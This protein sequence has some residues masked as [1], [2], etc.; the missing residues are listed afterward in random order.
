[1]IRPVFLVRAAFA[2]MTF[3]V[4]PVAAPAVA[5]DFR[6]TVAAGKRSAI[7]SFGT[8]NT[9]TCAPSAVPQVRVAQK[10]EHGK[11]EVVEERRVMNAGRCGRVE[12]NLMM[13]YY[14][15]VAGYRGP[16]AGSID[17]FSFAF[18]EGQKMRSTRTSFQITVK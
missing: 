4:M 11:I 6:S 2:A 8:Y 13:I 18:A 1:M 10:P 17:F 9:F 16:D 12:A 3:A 14:T 7:G 5:D 15:P